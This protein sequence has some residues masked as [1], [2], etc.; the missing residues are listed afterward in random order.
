MRVLTLS[1]HPLTWLVSKQ[2]SVGERS[3]VYTCLHIPISIHCLDSMKPVTV[4]LCYD[5]LNLPT[6]G[7]ETMESAAHGLKPLRLGATA[8]LSSF[9]L[10][11]SGIWL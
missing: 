6:T 3:L 5:V 7:P 10:T 9:Q 4:P 11:F 2:G 8:S 1:I